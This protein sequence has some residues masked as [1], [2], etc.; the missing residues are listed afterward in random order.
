[1]SS[2]RAGWLAIAG[3]LAIATT[4]A[5]DTAPKAHT[6]TIENMKFDPENLTVARGER[7]VWVNKDFF[8][9]TA[10]ARG[11]AFDSKEIGAGASW[12]YVAETAGEYAYGCTFHPP[13]KGR[14]V[15][16]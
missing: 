1:V 7:V 3:S 9:H 13:M 14:L 5:A 6:I 10:T 15:V 4:C 12:E 16:R 2:A 8:P 11:N